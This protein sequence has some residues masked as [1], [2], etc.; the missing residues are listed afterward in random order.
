LESKQLDIAKLSMENDK[1]L[2]L[3]RG[4]RDWR[5]YEMLLAKERIVNRRL[6]SMLA[7]QSNEKLIE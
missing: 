6:M 2:S 5:E 1:F 3:S 7:E 4:K